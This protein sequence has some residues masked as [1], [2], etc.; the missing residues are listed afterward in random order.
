MNHSDFQ[1]YV[2]EFQTSLGDLLSASETIE[3][4]NYI[5]G[6]PR[7][8]VNKI[9]EMNPLS[10]FISEEYGG[11]GDIPSQC[12]SILEATAYESI[13]V[14]LMMGINGSLFL[15]PVSKYGTPEIKKRVFSRFLNEKAMGGLMITE[16]EFGTDALSMQT[17]YQAK[18]S[19]YHIQG[20]KHWGGLTGIADFWLV[21]ARHKKTETRLARDIDLF[22]CEMDQPGQRIV[23][24][25][26][27]HKLG[28]FLIPYGL[29][30]IDITVPAETR[31]VP[32]SSGLKLM[33]DLLHRSRLRLSG[34]GLGF[35][36]RMQDE[37]IAHCQSR[38]VSGTHLADY[39]QVQ[40]RLA[41]LQAF[42]T[43]SSALCFYASQVSDVS[44]DLSPYGLQ[45][46]ASKALL[47]EMMQ[48]SAQSLVQLLGAKAYRRDNIAGRAIVDSRP[49]QIFEGSNDVM[50]SQIADMIIKEMKRVKEM[51]LYRFFSGFEFTKQVADRFKDFLN[52]S[53][54]PESIQRIKVKLG[55]ISAWA[56]AIQLVTELA[57]QGFRTDLI[58]NAIQITSETMA[59]LATG[60]QQ[61]QQVLLV[62]G[63][64]EGGDWKQLIN[65]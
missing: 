48:D 64:Q 56:I 24:E 55:T 59:E 28:L 63:Y 60:I 33:M 17:S 3:T 1:Q 9:L 19:G 13:A 44:T 29:N 32:K 43:I 58:E 27:Y 18:E 7:P 15:E 30:K 62:E 47:T 65:S 54:D 52:I 26:Y 34:I 46:N 14:A 57:S 16:P 37:A 20:K 22:V 50:F 10:T 42:Y 23:V 41:Q 11:L 49:F 39:D 31:L 12:L 5:E 61:G 8:L 45:A 38:V 21:T 36:K 40:F 6:L 25:E 53:I 51:N 35:I 2:K 4:T